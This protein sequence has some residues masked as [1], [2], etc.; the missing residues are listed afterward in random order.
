MEA[1]DTRTD[2]AIAEEIRFLHGRRAE[3]KAKIGAD[4]LEMKRRKNREFL[5]WVAAECPFSQRT[6][7]NYMGIAE[8]GEVAKIASFPIGPSVAYQTF[9]PSTPEAARTE[10]LDRAAAG[11]TVTVAE[12]E[13][14][15][16]RHRE[17]TPIRTAEPWTPETAE[18]GDTQEDEQ[19]EAPDR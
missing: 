1:G 7:Y 4:L 8:G 15:I 12:A 13:A 17:P 14:T 19:E 3:D 10:I 9:A 2:A 6:A 16:A 5:A 11:E 18:G